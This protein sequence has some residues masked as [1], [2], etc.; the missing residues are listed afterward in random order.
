MSQNLELSNKNFKKAIITYV[1][2]SKINTI[3]IKGKIEIFSK[4]IESIKW[5]SNGEWKCN[6]IPVILGRWKPNK[7]ETKNCT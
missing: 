6:K 4:E 3:K 1:P 2:E 7:N 5:E